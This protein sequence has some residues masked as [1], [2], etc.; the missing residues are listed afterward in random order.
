MILHHGPPLGPGAPAYNQ[1]S[2]MITNEGDEGDDLTA[3][4]RPE[5]AAPGELPADGVSGDGGP[6]TLYVVATPIGNLGDIT[7]RALETL[8]RVRLVAAEDTRHTGRLLHHFEIKTRLVSYHAHN[9]ARR[10][11]QLVQALA[12]GDIALVSDAGTPAISDPGQELVRAASAAGYA[13]VPIPGPSAAIAAVSISGLDT[14]A[15][16]FVGFLPRRTSERTR[17]LR[18]VVDWPG[19]VVCFEAPHRLQ[20]CLDDVLAVAGNREIAVCCELTK[21]FEQVYRGNVAGAVAHFAQTPPRGE[22]TVVLAG[23]PEGERGGVARAN[24]GAA[25]SSD[26][27]AQSEGVDSEAVAARFAALVQETGDR[28][29]ALS[30]LAAETGLPRKVLYARFMRD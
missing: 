1:Q 7:L 15:V 2:R 24:D 14:S 6:G 8:R 12:Q 27:A 9:R 19:V 28:R 21:R 26:Q 20:A 10:T 16:H 3:G 30:T 22:F 18:G 23:R 11:Q 25:A 29:V 5:T 4:E 13:V 17:A